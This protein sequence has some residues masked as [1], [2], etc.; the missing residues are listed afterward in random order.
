MMKQIYIRCALVSEH[1]PTLWKFTQIA[2]A[3][4]HTHQSLES[5]LAKIYKDQGLG[6]L[7][8]TE[9]GYL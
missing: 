3:S 1:P 5:Y 7:C 4:E 9:R 2:D 8:V 6:Y